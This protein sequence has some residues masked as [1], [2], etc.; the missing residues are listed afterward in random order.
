MEDAFERLFET[1]HQSLF[2]FIFYMVRHRETAE[3]L[4]QEVYIKVLQ[5]F[6]NFEGK[7]S[8]KTWIYSVAR[9]V[10]IDYIRKQNRKKRK[11]FGLVGSIDEIDIRDDAPLPEEIVTKR[12]EIRQIYKGLQKCT[13]DQQQVIVLRYIEALSIYETAEI[14][15]WSESKVKTTQHRAIKSLK[16]ILQQPRLP[17]VKEG[18]L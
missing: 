10:T 5:S 1:Y 13:V 11:W 14:L 12:D 18:Q 15:G 7:S 17:E 4:V 8:E 6:E 16:D 9:H 2:Q 3:E